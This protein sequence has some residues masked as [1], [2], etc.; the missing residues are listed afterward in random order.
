MASEAEEEDEEGGDQHSESVAPKIPQ[1]CCCTGF[2]ANSFL[3]STPLPAPVGAPFAPGSSPQP[4]SHPVPGLERPESA[5]QPAPTLTPR[6]VP[7]P[8]SLRDRG[9]PDPTGPAPGPRPFPLRNSRG[10]D[11]DEWGAAGRGLPAGAPANLGSGSLNTWVDG[12]RPG[13]GGHLHPQACGGH[14]GREWKKLV[15]P[16]PGGTALSGNG[17]INGS[18]WGFASFRA[19]GRRGPALPWACG[20]GR[21]HWGAWG[22]NRDP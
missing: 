4:R 14:G 22:C 1:T 16:G 15:S 5:Q 2:L 21:G 12:G 20:S 10:R 17:A 9:G 18:P 6:R 8:G 19:S 11:A 13:W 3:N 7:R